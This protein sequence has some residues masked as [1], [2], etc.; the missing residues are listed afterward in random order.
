MRLSLRHQWER[1]SSREVS[2]MAEISRVVI[3]CR[4]EDVLIIGTG[5]AGRE[6]PEW[7]DGERTGEP[8]RRDG[9]A[10]H[11][12]SGVSVSLGGVG[13]DGATVETT[14]PLESVEAG[15]IFRAAGV[16]EVAARAEAKPGYGQDARPRGVQVITVFVERLEPAGDITTLLRATPQTKSA[17][18]SQSGSS[19]RGGEA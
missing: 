2:V 5:G 12:L 1:T 11:R 9:A 14:T 13:L 19:A 15:T 8:V 7:R 3:P 10:V 18:A 6:R 4:S 16:V 17:A